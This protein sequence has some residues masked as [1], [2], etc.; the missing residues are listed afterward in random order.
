MGLL[1]ASNRLELVD[2]E[3]GQA[4]VEQCDLAEAR[5]HAE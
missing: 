3:R 4:G 2:D 5:V 1:S